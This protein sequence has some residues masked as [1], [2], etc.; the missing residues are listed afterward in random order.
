MTLLGKEI[1]STNVERFVT[2][3]TS[4]L[5]W[6]GSLTAR[7]AHSVGEVGASSNFLGAM[8]AGPNTVVASNAHSA[9]DSLVVE[10]YDDDSYARLDLLHILGVAAILVTIDPIRPVRPRSIS[11]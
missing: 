8:Q 10:H 9:L 3:A 2:S 7:L 6:P 5:L 1:E 11:S 4:H